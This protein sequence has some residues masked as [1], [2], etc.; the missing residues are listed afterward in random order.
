MI[1][2]L[3]LLSRTFVRSGHSREMKVSQDFRSI[4]HTRTQCK[5][6]KKKDAKLKWKRSTWRTSDVSRRTD[7]VSSV[8]TP[9]WRRRKWHP[10]IYVQERRV[11][12]KSGAHQDCVACAIVTMQGNRSRGISGEWTSTSRDKRRD[13]TMTSLVNI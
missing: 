3:L 4:S 9:L 6:L 12:Y 13:S 2:Y 10:R 8:P 7:S 5:P 1:I 11:T